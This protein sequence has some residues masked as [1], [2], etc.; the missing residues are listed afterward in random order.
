VYQQRETNNV[1]TKQ[2]KQTDITREKN[3]QIK[4]KEKDINEILKYINEKLQREIS[5]NHREII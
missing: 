3:K 5:P 4:H 1:S 2:R